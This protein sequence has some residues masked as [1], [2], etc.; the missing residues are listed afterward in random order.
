MTLI[1]RWVYYSGE[2]NVIC[3]CTYQGE[4]SISRREDGKISFAITTM[5]SINKTPV[6]EALAVA[7]QLWTQTTRDDR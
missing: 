6:N 5:A 2:H 1:I 3:H 4:E 7:G